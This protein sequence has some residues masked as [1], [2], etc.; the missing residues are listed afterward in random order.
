[1][2][3][4]VLLIVLSTILCFSANAQNTVMADST[5]LEGIVLRSPAY[6]G[7]TRSDR[8]NEAPFAAKF[9]VWNDSGAVVATFITNDEGRFSLTLPPGTY[10][11]VPDS[12]APLIH[13][14]RQKKLVNVTEG[15]FISINLRF[16]TGLR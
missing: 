8:P 6:P 10:S 7:P 4:Q 5:G 2:Q 1:M 3:P 16:D 14:D 12:S 11:I 13:P 15:N 9:E